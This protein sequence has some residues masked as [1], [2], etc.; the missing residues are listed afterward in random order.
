V[1]IRG[2]AEF[3]ACAENSA[4]HSQHFFIATEK[5]SNENAHCSLVSMTSIA[6]PDER[7]IG[8]RI[9]YR[10]HHEATITFVSQHRKEMAMTDSVAEHGLRSKK[11][12]QA[13]D[14]NASLSAF[15]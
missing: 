7:A 15:R 12:A 9:A 3:S 13:L 11:T 6:R 14:T 5:F 4:D 1:H 2:E 8:M 10:L